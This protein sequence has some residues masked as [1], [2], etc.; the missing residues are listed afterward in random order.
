MHPKRVTVW[1]GFWSI[2]IIGAFFFENEQEEAVTVNRDRYRTMLNEFLFTKIEEEEIG[3]I[4]FQQHGA[5]CHTAKAALDVL[6]PVFEDHI[7]SHR[8]DSFGHLRAAIWH[9]WTI[10]CAVKDFFSRMSKERSLQSMAIVIGPC[11]TNF[12]LQKLKRRILTTFGFNRTALRATLPKLHSM[13][14]G[15]FLKIALSAAVLMSFG[16]LELR[17]ET[18]GLLFVGCRQR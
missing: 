8:A 3:S 5:N 9:R 12:C 7:T 2:G 13:F 14:Y 17:F 18:V 11:W 16:Y 6:R 10:S 1:S 4:W 15:L